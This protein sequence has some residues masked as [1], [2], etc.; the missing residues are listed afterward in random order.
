[1]PV[2][3]SIW[4][5]VRPAA[6]RRSTGLSVRG[7]IPGIMNLLRRTWQSDLTCSAS[8][9]R[10]TSRATDDGLRPF[11]DNLNNS[12]IRW[13][14]LELCSIRNSFPC[15]AGRKPQLPDWEIVMFMSLLRRTGGEVTRDAD[16]LMREKGDRAFAVAGDMSWREDAGLLRTGQ[17]GHWSRVQ[18]E[19]G[20]RTGRSL[21]TNEVRLDGAAGEQAA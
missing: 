13:D 14:A 7:A 8:P 11:G 21:P 3:V 1:M 20:R 19:I 15:N 12:V 9:R 4:P 5:E 10:K 6:S 17:L 18:A 16:L 2:P